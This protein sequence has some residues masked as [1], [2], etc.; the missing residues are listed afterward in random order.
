[1]FTLARK[2][3]KSKSW[4]YETYG[5]DVKLEVASNSFVELPSR[6]Y[7]SNLSQKFLMD[8]SHLDFNLTTIF[9]NYRI[10]L[11]A[12][13]SYFS[14]CAV[15]GCNC[16]DIEI[17]HVKKLHRKVDSSG[18]VSLLNRKGKRVKGLVAI[19]SANNRK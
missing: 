3:N 6:D 1:M 15:Q 18:Q 11:G 14:R 4:A 13:K 8:E 5:D 16:N 10:R 7:V 19:F 9:N 17:H 12:G 2:H